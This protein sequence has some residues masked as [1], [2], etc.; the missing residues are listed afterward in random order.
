MK[1]GQRISKLVRVIPLD[2]IFDGDG[3]NEN[4]TILGGVEGGGGGSFALIAY[5]PNFVLDY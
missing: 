3:E 2:T 1:A 4:I 5:T